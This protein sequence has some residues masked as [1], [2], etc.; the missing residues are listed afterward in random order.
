L[1]RRIQEH[2]ILEFPRTKEITIVFEGRELV[3]HEGDTVASALFTHFLCC[4]KSCLHLEKH[5]SLKR[6]SFRLEKLLVLLV[7][8]RWCLSSWNSR[9][10]SRGKN[11]GREL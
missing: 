11:H 1:S 6:K 5:S 2:P 9:Y 7:L 3:A 4:P 8:S 10:C